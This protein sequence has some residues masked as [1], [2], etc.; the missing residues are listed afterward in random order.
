[1]ARAAYS[2]SEVILLDDTL[3]ALDAY[4][5]QSIME[6]CILNGPM[7]GRTRILATHALHVLEK[8]DHIYVMDNGTI[9][10]HGTYDV[11]NRFTSEKTVADVSQV[12]AFFD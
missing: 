4:V 1:L 5:G 7:A 11:G 9:I 2:Q 12:I 6:N 8:T 10:E 3:S